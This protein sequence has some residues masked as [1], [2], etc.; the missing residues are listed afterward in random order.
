MRRLPGIAKQ[1]AQNEV[2]ARARASER[3]RRCEK[4]ANLK[5]ID[6]IETHYRDVSVQ[7]MK[8]HLK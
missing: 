2:S 1:A 4:M 6:R 3:A 8:M 5:E 7:P